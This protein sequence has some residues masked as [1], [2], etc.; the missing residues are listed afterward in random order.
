MRKINKR[1]VVSVIM[2]VY[3][4][5]SFLVEAIESILRQTYRNFELII[6]D[7]GSTDNSWQLIKKYKAKYPNKLKIFHLENRINYAGNG[8][9]NHGMRFARGEFIARMD[10][11][12][13]AYKNRLK[14]QVEYLLNHTAVILLGTQAVIIDGTG[15]IIGKKS[16]PE[17]HKE[18]YES[19]GVVHPMIHPTC[20]IRRSLLPDK[21]RIY[22]GKF[23]VNAD[24][25]TF[26]K[27]LNYGKFANLPDIL[28]KYRMHEGN[29]SLKK[30]KVTFLNSIKIRIRAVITLHYRMSY[31]SFILM[32]LQSLVII[33]IPEKLIVPLY[34]YYKKITDRVS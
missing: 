7:D 25:Y 5:G 34:I 26:F 21:N 31:K 23:G 4:A 24:Y 10:A 13:I 8:A 28:L 3:N 19:Y 30:P 6:V 15:V 2:P 12:D 17:T 18:I 11:D 14:K 29:F 20:M 16:A 27:L 9:V 32:I 1:P 33:P 22:E